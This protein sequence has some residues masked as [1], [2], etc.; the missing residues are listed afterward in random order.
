MSYCTL[1]VHPGIEKCLEYVSLL[2]HL[3]FA[4]LALS[5][6]HIL[7][8]F[9]LFRAPNA[10]ARDSLVVGIWPRHKNTNKRTTQQVTKAAKSIFRVILKKFPSTIRSI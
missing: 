3:T 2:F 6:V 10:A 8:A 1:P 9:I 7:H 5:S 4:L